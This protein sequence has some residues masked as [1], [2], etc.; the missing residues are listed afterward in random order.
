MQLLI[1]RLV[2][3]PCCFL[4]RVSLSVCQGGISVHT[5]NVMWPHAIILPLNVGH[6]RITKYFRPNLQMSEF[7]PDNL[8]LILI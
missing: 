3:G 8:K 7:K 6:D 4:G 2:G 5:T 1:D